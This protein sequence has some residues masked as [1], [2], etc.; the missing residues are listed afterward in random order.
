MTQSVQHLLL[1]FDALTDSEKHVA[2]VEML[3]RTWPEGIPA[4]ADESLIEA[5]DALF[6]DLDAREAL[7]ARA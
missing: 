1:A 4:L 7:D 3:R 6:A 5:A 2:A